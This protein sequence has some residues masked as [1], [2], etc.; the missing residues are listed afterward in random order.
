VVVAT[1]TT[2]GV[3]PGNYRSIEVEPGA[4]IFLSTGTY[5]VATFDIDPTA[6]VNLETSVGPV[7]IVVQDSLDWRSAV[8]VRPLLVLATSLAAACGGRIA[9]KSQSSGPCGPLPGSASILATSK[10]VLGA[11]TT[12][13]DDIYWVEL[14]DTGASVAMQLARTGGA[15]KTIAT[16]QV[17]SGNSAATDDTYIYWTSLRGVLERAPKIG[18]TVEVLAA[19]DT[20]QGQSWGQLALDDASVYWV[21]GGQPPTMVGEV[22]R[23]AKPGGPV[24]VIAAGQHNPRDVV[25][26][27]RYV[28]WAALD[29]IWRWSKGP[30][31]VEHL[32][33]S[34]IATAGVEDLA[35]DD[36]FLYWT[37]GRGVRRLPLGGGAPT[38]VFS[39][40]A[41]GVRLNNGCL[42]L[43]VPTGLV[44]LS[45]SGGPVAPLL[46]W[47]D[48]IPVS[49]SVDDLGVYWSTA[50]TTTRKCGSFADDEASAKP[51]R[52][53]RN[54]SRRGL[55]HRG[56]VRGR[57]TGRTPEPPTRAARPL[58]RRCARLALR[59]A[60]G[61][62]GSA[63]RT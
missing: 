50:G 52:N 49:F 14:G 54:L 27:D 57:R 53:S 48:D 43:A 1:G 19:S 34:A 5:R 18:G 29:G 46:G 35:L 55:S 60:P 58:W 63:W 17:S 51:S 8:I 59:Q 16:G 10:H 40:G 44:R 38:T 20:S 56:F 11:V 37:D 30:S 36:Q 62:G 41:S 32:V 33:D 24:T 4:T 21:N 15:P 28:Y 3:P 31:T 47:G 7:V 13:R 23:V 12:D 45:I 22:M 6:T 26:N 42:Y 25:A 61:R 39:S 9:G 2:L